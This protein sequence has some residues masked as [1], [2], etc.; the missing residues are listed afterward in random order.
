MTYAGA[1]V[2]ASFAA[3][4]SKARESQSGTSARYFTSMVQP[5]P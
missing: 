5:G 4:C 3:A 2:A 1:P